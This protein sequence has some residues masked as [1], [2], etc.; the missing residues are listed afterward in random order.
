M[1]L[2]NYVDGRCVKTYQGHTNL[3]FSLSGA[4]GTYGADDDDDDDDDDAGGPGHKGRARGLESQ[5]FVVSGSEDGMVVWWDVQSKE[6]LQREGGH[7][8][9]VLGVDTWGRAG[10]G[11]GLVV[12]GGVDWT[13]R[14]WERVG[15]GNDGDGDGDSDGDDDGEDNEGVAD[16]D[17][18]IE[19]G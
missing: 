10:A 19:G 7:E 4:F 15:K 6:V 17:E 9:V 16:E 14:V 18:E 3:K 12:S 13:V 2:W 5:A 1:R 8:G 11:G